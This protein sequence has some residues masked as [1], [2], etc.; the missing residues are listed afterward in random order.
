MDGALKML[1]DVEGLPALAGAMLEGGIY[2]ETV[3]AVMGTNAM[4][5]VGASLR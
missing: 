1:I 2:R 4:A 5:L 3:T